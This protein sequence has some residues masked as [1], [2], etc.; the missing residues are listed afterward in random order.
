LSLLAP[1][2]FQENKK[3]EN[4][5]PTTRVSDQ[6][7]LDLGQSRQFSTDMS[8]PSTSRGLESDD[9]DR[10]EQSSIAISTKFKKGKPSRCAGGSVKSGAST[11]GSTVISVKSLRRPEVIAELPVLSEEQKLRAMLGFRDEDVNKVI[12]IL[13]PGVCI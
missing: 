1:P 2:P 8:R 12:L 10:E 13:E 9:D 6:F 4:T 5:P 11:T 3:T 7:V